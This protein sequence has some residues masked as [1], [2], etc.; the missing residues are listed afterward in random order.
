[1]NDRPL[2]ILMVHNRHLVPGGEDV[3][4]QNEKQL[5][6]SY[7][8]NVVGYELDNRVIEHI[9]RFWTAVRTIWS[10]Q[11]YREIRVILQRQPFDCV[12]VQNF[13]PLISPSVF[14]AAKRERVP[15]ILYLHN[16]RLFCLNGYFFRQGRVCEDCLKKSVPWPG[17][18]HRCYRGS[19]SGS[20][21]VAAM[22]SIHRLLR[23]WSRKVDRFI[24]LSKFSQRKFIE[25]GI[26]EGQLS[27][28]PNFI[29]PDPG[30][31]SGEGGYAIFVGRLS[32]EKGI[33]QLLSAWKTLEI[34]IPLK[35]LGDGPLRSEVEIA[36]K[37]APN[38]NL[39][40]SVSKEQVFKYLKD[41]ACLIFPSGWYEN[42]PMVILEA[43]AVGTPVIAYDLGSISEIVIPG[44]TGYL[45]PAGDVNA[46]K[47]CVRAAFQGPSNLIAMRKSTRQEYLENYSRQEN[48]QALLKI[49][50]SVLAS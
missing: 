1:M 27:L 15:S 19:Y 17:I 9:G 43:Y 20:F 44:R 5:L 41:A 24:A 8:H 4:Y 35:I 16:F 50:Q 38:I 29:A 48:Y 14:F 37:D 39:M 23:T 6:E 2:T 36:V 12:I 32:P 33:S 34:K 22:L 13:F 26:S 18:L 21:V 40:G 25:G 11:T 10:Q 30:I 49:I 42:F 46:L 28:K 45:I 47:E 31:G 7:G 3:V